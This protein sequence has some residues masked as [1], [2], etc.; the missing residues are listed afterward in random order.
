MKLFPP[1]GNFPLAP[2][3]GIIEVPDYTKIRRRSQ[4]AKKFP[5]TPDYF[6]LE[7]NE[8]RR[9]SYYFMQSSQSRDPDHDTGFTLFVPATTKAGSHLV[10]EW[11]EPKCACARFA[12]EAEIAEAT[13]AKK[14]VPPEVQGD[15]TDWPPL[16]PR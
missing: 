15:T 8:G 10:I 14:T 9:S 16:S 11:R 13:T 4:H 7:R 2:G 6:L 12:T 3:A 5:E 1:Q